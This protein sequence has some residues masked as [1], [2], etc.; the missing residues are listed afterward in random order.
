MMGKAALS[1]PVQLETM[2]RLPAFMF[3]RA[4]SVFG[5]WMLRLFIRNYSKRPGVLHR[6][7]Q[8]APRPVENPRDYCWE[9]S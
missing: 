9:A 3:S 8:G 7:L 6:P 1:E 5:L 2:V 4:S